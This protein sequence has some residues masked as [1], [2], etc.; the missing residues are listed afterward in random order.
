MKFA[1]AFKTLRFQMGIT[2]GQLARALGVSQS[3]ISKMER[4]HLAPSAPAFIWGF[5]KSRRYKCKTLFN[6]LMRSV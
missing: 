3:C 6:Q 4:G 2:Q 5:R 1:E